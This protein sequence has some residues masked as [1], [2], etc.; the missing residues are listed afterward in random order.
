MNALTKPRHRLIEQALT[1]ARDWCAGHV[2]DDR[3]WAQR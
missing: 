2:I 1:D 3:W